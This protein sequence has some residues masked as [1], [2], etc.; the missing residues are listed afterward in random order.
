MFNL[1]DF[2]LKP[3]TELQ[4]THP[5]TGKAIDGFT[6]EII[7]RASKE[8]E[9]HFEALRDAMKALEDDTKSSK[10]E[11]LDVKFELESEFLAKVTARINGAEIDGKAIGD[12]KSLIFAA[13]NDRAWYWLRDQV[14]GAAFGAKNFL[15]P[16]LTKK[17]KKD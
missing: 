7:G 4:I 15:S 10:E 3:A 9:I 14:N 16:P 12:D 17:A 8:F 13:Y 1:N 2:R 11:K 5:E 6:V